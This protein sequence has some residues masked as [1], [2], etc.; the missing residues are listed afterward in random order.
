MNT[1]SIAAWRRVGKSILLAIMLALGEQAAGSNLLPPPQ[2]TGSEIATVEVTPPPGNAGRKVFAGLKHEG[3]IVGRGEATVTETGVV[4]VVVRAL[5]K[6]TRITNGAYDL[7]LVIDRDGL[8]SCNPSFGDIYQHQVWQWPAVGR[9]VELRDASAWKLKKPSSPENVIT[10]HYHRYDE[11]YTDVG[12]WTWDGNYKR[13]P[14]QNERFEVGRDE[15]GPIFQI[16]RSEYGEHGDSDKIGVLPR[17][18]LSWDRKDGD[19]KFWRP[20]LGRE[21][22]LIE[23]K[24]QVFTIRP[25]ITPQVVA[26]YIDAP[27]LLVV[28]TSRPLGADESSADKTT[29]KDDRGQEVSVAST[30][31]ILSSRG[32]KSNTIE[33]TTAQP[34][35]VGERVYKVSVQNFAGAAQAVPRGVLNDPALYGDTNAVLG[36][37]YTPRATTFRVFAPTAAAGRVVV[38]D[39]ATGGQGRTVHPM[40]PAGKG[41]WEC[42]VSGDLKGKFYV[43]SLDGTELSPDHEVVDIYA[44]NTVHNTTRAR[45]TDLAETNPDGWE[46]TKKGPPLQSPVDM[47]VYEMHVRDFTIATNS[48]ATPAHR[49]KYLGFAEAADY[50]KELGVTHVQLMPLQDF[51]NDEA[52]TNYNWGYVT[53]AFNSPDGWFATNIDD[54]SRVR[55]FKRLVGALHERGI[56]VIMDVVYNHTANG[57]PF[58]ALVPR[59]YYRYLPDGRLSNGSGC[60]NDFRTEAPMARKYIV[61]SLKYWVQEYGIDGF[62]FDLMALMDL[63]TMKEVER[64]LRAINPSI[65]LYGEPW[66]GGGQQAPARPT[67]KQTIVGTHL[68]AFNDNIRDALVGS[69][70]DK[71]NCGFVQNGSSRNELESAIQGSFR[72][73]A[74]RPDQVINFISCHDNWVVWDKLRLSKPNATEDDVKDMMKIGYL[75]LLTAQGVPFIHGGD[76]FARTKYGNG[77]SYNAPDAVNEVDWSLRKKNQDLF[78]YVRDLIAFRKAHPVFRIRAKEQ[79]AAWLKFVDTGNPNVLMFTI[80]GSGVEGESRKQVCVIVNAADSSSADVALPAGEWHIAFDGN[81]AVK[82]SRLV[83]GTT[84]VRNKSGQILFQP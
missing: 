30:R 68:G 16:D 79:I 3:R 84:R 8:Q 46:R 33:L 81:G 69:P 4:H 82:D 54:D 9:I 77:N 53:M 23:T 57:A 19:D 31:P 12:I 7:W 25:D 62:R 24:N 66:G 45:I 39:K 63:D 42:A 6:D 22:Y 40:K 50:L 18:E 52:S 35:D 37:A 29:V 58:N 20:E 11:D 71:A 64:E 26:A 14:E 21:I 55:E 70:F 41:I 49:G 73:W 43:Y 38:Y 34:L 44:V 61:D 36:A 5:D 67:N 59:Y 75:L 1:K 74:D 17:L 32:K 56:G 60:G 76:E 65:V 47:V 10:V 15:Y 83:Q 72:L 27:T 2:A 78:T 51:E 80:D 13:S 28:Q 48:S